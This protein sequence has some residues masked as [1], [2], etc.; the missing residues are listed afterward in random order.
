MRNP[1]SGLEERESIQIR[2][3]DVEEL[4]PKRTF[5]VPKAHFVSFVSSRPVLLSNPVIV[6]RLQPNAHT[7][8]SFSEFF[9]G[10]AVITPRAPVCLFRKHRS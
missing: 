3:S 5:I 10:V 1:E 4:R 6:S 2:L 8:L 7:Q 9:L